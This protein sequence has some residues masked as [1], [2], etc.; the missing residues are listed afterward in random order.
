MTR[1]TRAIS[2]FEALPGSTR[3]ILWMIFAT[4]NYAATY[5][6]VRHLSSD[7][8]VFQLVFF[9]SLCGVVFMAPWLIRNGAG[10]LK[11]NHFGSYAVRSTLN[12]GGM[13]L[14]VFALATLPLQ[15]VTGLMFTSPLFTVLFVVLILGEGAGPRRWA[16]LIIGFMGAMIIIRPGFQELSLGAIGV[17]GTSCAYA[18]INVSTKKLAKT[19]SSNKI[20]Y[21][22]FLLMTALGVLP[23]IWFWNEVRLEHIVWILAMGVV[24]ALAR[25]GIIR[26]LAV[27]EASVVM[28]FNFLKLP[29]TVCLGFVFF[30]ENPDLLTG[31]GAA[32]IFGSSYYIARREAALKARESDK[33][34]PPNV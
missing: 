34:P 11:T 19:D 2:V 28:P 26:A 7:F 15:D 9:R 33:P 27:G 4:C 5:A 23:A 29:F 10:V 16:A 17:I 25:Q 22:D 20:V 24:S 1:L 13:L 31:I 21:Y 3:G 6:I 30:A 8:T 18:L 14:L 12:Y 32:V